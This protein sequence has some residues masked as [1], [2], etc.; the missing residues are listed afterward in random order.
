MAVG[1]CGIRF[2]GT[3]L[4]ETHDHVMVLNSEGDAF[5]ASPGQVKV[6][7]FRAYL[8]MP[9]EVDLLPLPSTDPQGLTEKTVDLDQ[10]DDAVYN[11]N[12]QR[13]SNPQRGLY[14]KNHQKVL[15]R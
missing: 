4:T 5:V 15:I 3:T 12:G 9:D 7:P 14:I 10:R 13:V 1:A 2:Y 11:L 6:Q 8:T